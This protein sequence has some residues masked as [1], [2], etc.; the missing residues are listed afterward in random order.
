MPPLPR[1][2]DTAQPILGPRLHRLGLPSTNGTRPRAS[3]SGTARRKATRPVAQPIARAA[4]SAASPAP[5]A[6]A[7]SHISPAPVSSR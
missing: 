6:R 3:S 7:T 1:H 5:N 2:G 4:T